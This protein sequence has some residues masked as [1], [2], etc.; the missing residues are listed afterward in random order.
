[1]RVGWWAQCKPLEQGTWEAEGREVRTVQ[2]AG[3]PSPQTA[4]VAG[5]GAH[6]QD[7]PPADYLPSLPE[8]LEPQLWAVS[9][10][11]FSTND[12]ILQNSPRAS[13]RS[14]QHHFNKLESRRHC[15]SHIV[16][17]GHRDPSL[18]SPKRSRC[19]W[20][21]GR[22]HVVAGWGRPAL[23]PCSALGLRDPRHGGWCFKAS[24]Q[25][26]VLV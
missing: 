22:G 4:G 26:P 15:W 10:D 18:S 19:K 14:G 6:I 20:W 5:A 23:P 8:A 7:L 17:G 16:G 1:M 11:R 24:P 9:K 3:S 13:E 21:P 25:I 2:G 12:L